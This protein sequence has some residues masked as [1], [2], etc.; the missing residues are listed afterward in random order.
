MLISND[1]MRVIN[2]NMRQ[3]IMG[4]LRFFTSLSQLMMNLW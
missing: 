2:K 3:I 1:D 4:E